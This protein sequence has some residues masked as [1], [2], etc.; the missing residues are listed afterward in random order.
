MVE[1]VENMPAGTLGFRLSG[2][3]N[4]D[5]YLLILGPIR[6]KLERGEKVSFLVETSDDFSGLDMGA[7]WEDIKAG[8]SVGLKYRSSWERLAVV[9]DKSWIRHGVAAFGWV[10]PGEIRIFES[11]ELEDAKT[12]TGGSA[13][14]GS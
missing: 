7:M 1:Q 8:G 10:I 2:K 4:L 14:S 13:G 9:T 5:E 3:V 12:W 6:E 11:D